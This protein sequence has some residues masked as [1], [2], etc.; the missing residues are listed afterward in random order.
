MPRTFLASLIILVWAGPV[1]AQ[2]APTKTP[3]S[4]AQTAAT[5][6]MR[7]PGCPLFSTL[8]RAQRIFEQLAME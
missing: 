5:T 7:H 1:L 4:G 2:S 3:D 6:D 8:P